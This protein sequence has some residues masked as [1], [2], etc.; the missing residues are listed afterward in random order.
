MTAEERAAFNEEWTEKLFK[1]GWI[2]ASW[3]IEYEG[4]GLTHPAERRAQRGV[5]PRRRAAARGLLRRHPRRPHDP[6]VG[7]R[8]AEAPVLAGDPARGDDVV[9]GVQRAEL[10]QRPRVACDASA[11]LDGDEWV[12]NGQKVWTTQAQHADYVFLLVRTD[13]DA[14]KHAGISYLLVPMRQPGVEVRPIIQVDGSADFNEVFFTDA[15]CS[16][17]QRRRR[18]EQRLEGRDD[19]ARLRARQLGD[20]ELPAVPQGVGAARSRTPRSRASPRTPSSRDRLVRSWADIKIMQINGYR[21]LTDALNGTHE[22]AK[23][24]ACNKMFWSESHRRTM[25]LALDVLGM[26]AQILEGSGA[27]EGFLPGHR[28]GPRRLPG[29]ATCRRASSSPGPRR[30]GAGPPRSSATSSASARSACRRSRRSPTRLGR[31]RRCRHAHGRALPG[32]DPTGRPRHRPS[33]PRRPRARPWQSRS[34]AMTPTT[35]API[36]VVPRNPIA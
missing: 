6:A 23:L 15:Q 26:R 25:E 13:P 10:G 4:K 12:I 8:G 21:T 28:T 20:H 11:V 32:R 5:R 19:D 22:A 30:S 18:R 3:P 29:R 17:G 1:G 31:S 36:G 27:S 24:G 16:D 33:R 9:P 7:H 34:S 35:N 2:C 14:P